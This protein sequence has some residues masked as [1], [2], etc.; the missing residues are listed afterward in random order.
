[1]P[2]CR[3]CCSSS[4][5]LR[6]ADPPA[7][8]APSPVPAPTPRW[9]GGG[10]TPWSRPAGPPPRPPSPGTA[11]AWCVHPTPVYLPL[12][13]P[14]HSLCLVPHPPPGALSHSATHQPGMRPLPSFCFSAYSF[15]P[16]PSLPLNS[17]E[18][19]PYSCLSF[20]HQNNCPAPVA[21]PHLGTCIDQLS[22]LPL[23]RSPPLPLFSSISAPS[24]L[25]VYRYQLPWPKRRLNWKILIEP[26]ES[27]KAKNPAQRCTQPL[28]RRKE[29]VQ[30]SIHAGVRCQSRH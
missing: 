27:C 23:L 11:L 9:S 29:K 13:P 30:W 21:R 15:P 3:A 14:P 4:P 18:P 24:P 1:M 5:P 8:C 22:Q 12:P 20:R 17:P 2:A 19:H 7:T 28:H 16:T 10:T 25:F 26:Y 6:R